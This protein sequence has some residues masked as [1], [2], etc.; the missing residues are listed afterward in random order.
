M[1]R[2][3]HDLRYAFRQMLKTPGFC[4]TAIFSL[5]L[6]IGAT[7]SVFSVIYSAILTPWPYAGFDRVCQLNTINK[8]GGEGSPGFTGPQVRE[9]RQAQAAEEVVAVDD[10][11]LTLTGSDAPEDVK[12]YYFSGNTFHFFGMP[13]MLGRY[14]GPSDAPDEGDPERVAVL[15]Y[16]FWQRH[17]AGDPSI[18]GKNIQ[19]EHKTYTI[20]GVMPV[21]FTWG[22]GDVYLPLKMAEDKDH[23]YGTFIKLK[24]GVRMEAAEAEFRPMMQHFDK[25]RP[26]FYPPNY[27]MVLRKMG[28]FYTRDLRSTLYFLFASVSLL[29]F[30]GCSNVSI[31]LLARG[32]SRYH[33]LAI[34]SALGATRFQIVIQ[35]L[36]ESLLLALVGAGIGVVI[37]YR[38]LDF[39][40]ARL[41][42]FSFPHEADF[43][44]NITVLL[45]SVGLAVVSGVLFGVFPALDS[46]RRDINK[47]IQAGTHKVAGNLR[48]HRAYTGLIA[49]QI[50]LT[51]LLLTGAG[52]AIQGFARMIRRPLGYEPHHVMSVGIP[53]HENTFTTWP[54]RAAYIA[55]LRDRVAETPGVIAAGISSNA[56]PPR[57]G[58]NLPFELLGKNTT[59]QQEARVHLVSPEYFSMLQIPLVQGRLWEQSEISRGAPLAVVNQAFVRR[60]FSGEDALNHS[61]RVPRLAEPSPYRL[62]SMDASG[63]LQI[64]G[65]TGDALD[66]GLDKPILPAVYLPYTNCMFMGT[67][68]LVRAEGDPLTLL[69]TIRRS[70]AT[71][72][73][74]QQA[75]ADVRDLNTWIMR[76]PEFANGRLVSI[77][78]GAFSALALGLAAVGLYSVVSYSVAQR[79]G[80]FGIRMALGAQRRDVLRIVL[81]S[82]ATSVGIGLGAGLLLSLGSGKV[83]ARW[84]QNGSHDPL[85]AVGVSLL[86]I[87]VAGLA[88]LVPAYRAIGVDPNKALRCE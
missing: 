38:A 10:W 18:V 5:A 2:V 68:I 51:L 69:R 25:E 67:Q 14:F 21:R 72:N 61:I 3:P 19:L 73:P 79:S 15:S 64:V 42:E 26:N 20:L 39:I 87:F 55:Q 71:I 30:I 65:V 83:I 22:D 84:V 1:Q 16:K 74:D 50:A 34:R 23:L 33:E 77:L 86:V 56:T 40:V 82:A 11:S 41:P 63:W 52:A 46:A 31:L 13:A 24:P 88:C 49:G 32:T 6:G 45:F 12:G 70:I 29:L 9:L 37:A 28:A 4:L 60:Y 17:F 81:W 85:I 48:R 53:I 75:S 54:E 7:V 59:E 43:H 78:F 80:E 8:D 58:W 57:S 44:V 62:T 76:E 66:D 27:R 36:T 47:A 35:L